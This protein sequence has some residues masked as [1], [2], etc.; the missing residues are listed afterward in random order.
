MIQEGGQVRAIF[1]GDT[2]YAWNPTT[3]LHDEVMKKLKLKG[4]ATYA[5]VFPRARLVHVVAGSQLQVS[6]LQSH[7][8]VHRMHF[9]VEAVSDYFSP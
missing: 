1:A 5:L 3:G 2:V 8:Y 6:H 7:P 9:E 4:S